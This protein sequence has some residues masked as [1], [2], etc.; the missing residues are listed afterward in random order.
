MRTIPS[1]EN[2]M[3]HNNVTIVICYKLPSRVVATAAVA[4]KHNIVTLVVWCCAFNLHKFVLQQ[5]A[6]R[7]LDTCTWCTLYNYVPVLWRVKWR[8]APWS[9]F[10]STV[11]LPNNRHTESRDLVLYR[12]VVPTQ[13][14]TTKPHPSIPRL[15]LLRGVAY[16]RLNQWFYPDVFRI[17]PRWSKSTKRK[18]KSTF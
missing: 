7:R 5:F 3:T 1:E 18:I 10:P 17:D 6:C 9:T 2:V 13:R 14:V 12:E 8:L 15:N 16:G 4:I 11:E